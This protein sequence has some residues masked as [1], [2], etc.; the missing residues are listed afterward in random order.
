MCLATDAENA[1]PSTPS[2]ASQGEWQ[3]IERD[4]FSLRVDPERQSPLAFALSVAEGLDS[5][6]R[7]LD[8]S[9]LYDAVGSALF[10][11]IT[12]QPEYY[13]TRAEDRLLADHAP[14]IRELAGS[15]T[16]VELGSG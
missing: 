2:L 8:A 13:L 16:L 9:Y 4:G 12:E 1:M 10:E 11:R 5:R 3:V 6:P 7:R 15:S 14:V